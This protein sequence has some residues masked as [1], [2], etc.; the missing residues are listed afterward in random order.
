MT[1][2]FFISFLSQTRNVSTHETKSRISDI[3]LTASWNL[4][5][6]TYYK[7]WCKTSS[8]FRNVLVRSVSHFRSLLLKWYLPTRCRCVLVC[9]TYVLTRTW[10]VGQEV[11]NP[12]CHLSQL[13]QYSDFSHILN[14]TLTSRC[15]PSY[16]SDTNYR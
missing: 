10:L 15:G 7:Q 8:K 3:N 16:P 14:C 11:T 2:L 13:C 5:Q 1:S 4:A 6:I 9:R 12:V